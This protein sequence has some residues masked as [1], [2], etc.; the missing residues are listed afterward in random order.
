MSIKST[1]AS[2]VSSRKLITTSNPVPPSK[3]VFVSER[4]FFIS[5]EVVNDLVCRDRRSIKVTAESLDNK[6]VRQRHQWIEPELPS[7][8][9]WNCSPFF[10][11]ISQRNWSNKLLVYVPITGKCNSCSKRI[12][13]PVLH[14][15]SKAEKL[16]SYF[17]DLNDTM[18]IL[19]QTVMF[20][21]ETDV[22]YYV[23]N[24]SRNVF[25]SCRRTWW[26]KLKSSDKISGQEARPSF[27]L[28]SLEVK[29]SS[30]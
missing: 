23:E 1:A 7:N 8:P 19:S 29:S 6:N 25:R 14:F 30:D 9:R 5:H 24:S 11:L 4:N 22:R 18:F 28:V 12:K 15:T 2:S 10:R 20:F 21:N 16:R 3:S 17:H 27:V 26:L 13:S